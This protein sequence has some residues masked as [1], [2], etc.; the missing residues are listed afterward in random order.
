MSAPPPTWRFRISF[1]SPVSVAAVS[2]AAC[3]TFPPASSANADA[4]DRASFA[5]LVVHSDAPSCGRTFPAAPR[6][7]SW[8]LMGSSGS[9]DNPRQEPLVPPA[10]SLFSVSSALKDGGQFSRHLPRIPWP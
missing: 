3:F 8:L 9:H 6:G 4:L 7:K 5:A 2:D 1:T 10:R